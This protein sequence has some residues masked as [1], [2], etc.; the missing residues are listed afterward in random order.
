MIALIDLPNSLPA[1]NGDWKKWPSYP[2]LRAV[3][4]AEGGL[5]HKFS[6]K[7]QGFFKLIRPL[8]EIYLCRSCIR[9]HRRKQM[10]QKHQDLHLQIG[11]IMCSHLNYPDTHRNCRARMQAVCEVFSNTMQ[12]VEFGL[13]EAHT[14]EHKTQPQY[15]C[16]CWEGKDHAYLCSSKDDVL[17]VAL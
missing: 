15:M 12:S 1:D 4:A 10:V 6:S 14:P 16:L 8:S 2:W 13:W 11:H 3:P 7:H 5:C 17:G 9:Y